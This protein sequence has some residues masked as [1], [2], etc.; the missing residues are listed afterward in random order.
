MP[1]KQIS[2]TIL[3]STFLVAG[4]FVTA[5]QK[6][7]SGKTKSQEGGKMTSAAPGLY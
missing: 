5:S 1:V 4:C 3:L 2:V 7:G 6:P